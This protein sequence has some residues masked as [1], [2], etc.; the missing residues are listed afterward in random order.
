MRINTECDR[1]DELLALEAEHG[2]GAVVDP[3]LHRHLAGCPACEAAVAAQRA[4]RK[5]LVTHRRALQI[6][7]PPGVRT[8]I[9][10]KLAGEAHAEAGASMATGWGLRLSPLAAAAA[11][12]LVITVGVLPMVTGQSSVVLAAQ[13]AL[14]HVKCFLIDGDVHATP[15]SAADAEATMRKQHGWSVPVSATG[16]VD[17]GHLVAVRECLYSEGMAAHLLYRVGETPVSLF[18]MPDTD[19]AVASVSI[20]ASDT[21]SWHQNGRTHM[22]VGPAGSRA[23]LDSMARHLQLEA[24]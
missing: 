9:A 10:A 21:V 8:R 18:V 19:H 23:T 15:I 3:A 4:V 12:M 22:L 7:A 14:D 5:R 11:L 17:D 16:G 24:R 13:L 20:L 6:T 2:D 1:F